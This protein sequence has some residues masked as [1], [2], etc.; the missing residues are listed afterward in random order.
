LYPNKNGTVKTLL[1]EAAKVVEFAED[2]TR[3]LRVNDV[4]GHK[5]VPGPSDDTPLDS[6]LKKK[7]FT[8]SIY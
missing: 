8:S 1:E 5:L 3:C 4:T 7:L 2:G 6:K